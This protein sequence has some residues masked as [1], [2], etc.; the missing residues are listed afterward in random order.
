M[1]LVADA[2]GCK[3]CHPRGETGKAVFATSFSLRN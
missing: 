2:G 3:A 1:N